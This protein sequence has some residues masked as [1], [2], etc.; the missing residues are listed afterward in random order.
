M[1][2]DD[3]E[4]FR[5]DPKE[6][7]C[8]ALNKPKKMPVTK[9]LKRIAEKNLLLVRVSILLLFPDINRSIGERRIQSTA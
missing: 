7:V 9:T 3:E 1:T 6:T 2:V 8:F 5:W 4:I